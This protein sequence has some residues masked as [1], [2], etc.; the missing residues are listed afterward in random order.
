MVEVVGAGQLGRIVRIQR[1]AHLDHT[2]TM[3]LGMRRDW[4]LQMRG[5][6]GPNLEGEH[7]RLREHGRRDGWRCGQVQV[8][9]V[10]AD[11]QVAHH[12]LHPVLLP[13]L[14]QVEYGRQRHL[15]PASQTDRQVR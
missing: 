11:E 14:G 3:I 13:A 12:H 5:E 1:T 8:Q 9:V 10:Q 4:R 15:T 7:E 2:Q 6:R